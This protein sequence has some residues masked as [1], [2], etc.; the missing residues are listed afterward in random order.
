MLFTKE[1]SGSKYERHFDKVGEIVTAQKT[2]EKSAPNSEARG[3]RKMAHSCHGWPYGMPK[4]Q[5]QMEFL[6]FS[7]TKH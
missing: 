2:C 4:K 5:L 7:K 1:T 3:R 6:P